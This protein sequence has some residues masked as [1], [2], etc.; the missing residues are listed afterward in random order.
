MIPENPKQPDII[1][2]LPDSRH[3]VVDSKV[4]LSAYNDYYN[5][6]SKDES[7]KNMFLGKHLESVTNHINELAAKDYHD[8][9]SINS[10]DFVLMFMPIEGA[11]HAALEEDQKQR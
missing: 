5:V 9:Y 1:I 7:S 8:I 6:D 4:S 11:L 3:I 10:L 2:N